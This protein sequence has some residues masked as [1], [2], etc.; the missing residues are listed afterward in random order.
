MFLFRRPITGKR[1]FQLA[2][3]NLCTGSEPVLVDQSDQHEWVN[4]PIGTEFS[5]AAPG[6]PV[7]ITSEADIARDFMGFW[8][9]FVSTFELE[10]R[11]VYTTGESYAGQYNPCIASAMLDANDTNYY[12]VK[13]MQINDPSINYH[14]TLIYAPSVPY[15]NEYANVFGLNETFT[16]DVNARAEKCGYFEFLDNA[17]TFPPKGTIPTAPNSSEPGYAV[18]DD[19]L[20]AAVYVNPC[21]NIYHII[22]FCPY[23]WDVLGIPSLGVGPNNYFNR[24]DVQ[25]AL[26]VPKPTS[27][28]IC[29]DDSLFPNGDQSVPSG[30]GSIPGVIEKTNNV[31]IGHGSLDFLLIANGSLVTIQNMTWNGKQ[32]FQTAPSKVNNFYVPYHQSLGSIESEL[33]SGSPKISAFQG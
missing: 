31:T 12:N 23:L 1:P 19:I 3:G 2:I 26:H 6:A 21:F 4:Q 18:W 9:N 11:K 22:D 20:T 10:G 28:L 25:K 33:V 32:G 13:G 27:F 17:L 30:L 16:A 7:K 15:L 5:P 8:K 14:D 24:T 29:G